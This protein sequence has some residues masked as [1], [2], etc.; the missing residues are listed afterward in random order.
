MTTHLLPQVQS[1]M[2]ERKGDRV[3][4][5]TLG[6]TRHTAR[7]LMREVELA[8]VRNGAAAAPEGFTGKDLRFHPYSEIFP[9]TEGDDFDGLVADIRDNGLIDDIWIFEGAILDGRNRYR[10]CA[11]AGIDI[12][13]DRFVH[14][15]PEVHG[16][17]LTFSIAKNLKRRHLNDDQRRMVA[18]RLANMRPGRPAGAAETPAECGV[19]IEE[20]ARLVNVDAAGT[21]R[22]RTVLARATPE[23]REAVDKGKLTVAAAAQA[24][25]LP[26]ETQR[27]IADEA[28]AGRANV[29]RTVIKK[30]TRDAREADLG[31]KQQALP[32]KKYGV[33]LADPE[34]RFEPYSRDTGMDRAPDNH[35]DT[36][37]T[38]DI[39]RR[40]VAAIA[41]KDAVL[42]LWA[43]APMLPQALAVMKAWGFEYKT[44][45]IWRKTRSG[46]G[47]GSG[48]WFTGEH[49]LVLVGTRGAIPAPATAVGPSVFDAPAGRHSAKP[50]CIAEMIEQLYPNLPKIEL[51]RRGAPRPGW[52]AWGNEAEPPH[53]PETGEIIEPD[54]TTVRV[55]SDGPAAAGQAPMPPQATLVDDDLDIPAFLKREKAEATP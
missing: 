45:R 4:A 33:I 5:E 17:P 13:L 36:S 46:D 23:V 50:E 29:V 12:P 15:K 53:D 2:A 3:I 44:H 26:E 35:Y 18:A 16:D 1:M 14:F 32:D 6:I 51:N 8:A 20:A 43:T 34:W 39:I 25:K 37:D 7:N 55:A 47:R 42:W 52:D 22:A 48:Y 27:K 38:I 21:E 9:L 10:A 30:E 28:K 19:K 11:A 41:A 24:S 40:P 54:A 31:R 49:E